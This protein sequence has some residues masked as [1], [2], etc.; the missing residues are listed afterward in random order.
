MIS[1]IARALSSR[2]SIFNDGDSVL[3]SRS[4][5]ANIAGT[6]ASISTRK[7]S[8]DG[9]GCGEAMGSIVPYC[10]PVGYD[11]ELMLKVQFRS[12]V[13]RRTTHARWKNSSTGWLES[14]RVARRRLECFFNEIE[15]S[16]SS[17]STI[18]PAYELEMR[19]RTHRRIAP[20]LH[21]SLRRMCRRL[22]RSG[23]SRNRCLQAFFASPHGAALQQFNLSTNRYHVMHLAAPV[24]HWQYQRIAMCRRGEELDK[25]R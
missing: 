21:H 5:C 11:P 7:S 25:S 18:T 9:L 4:S 19:S 13:F 17:V 14:I 23:I 24:D 16:R 12:K 1:A 15:V 2:R 6:R 10:H 3:T 20:F 22:A 8:I